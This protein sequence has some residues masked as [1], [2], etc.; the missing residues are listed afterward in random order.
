MTTNCPVH[1]QE[2]V[3]RFTKTAL[4]VGL[5]AAV[6]GCGGSNFDDRKGSPTTETQTPAAI[7][8]PIIDCGTHTHQQGEAMSDEV[9]ACLLNA[10]E[11]GHP[12][13]LKQT[14]PT[15]EGD[16]ITKTYKVLSTGHVEIVTDN[17]QD[18]LGS[19]GIVAMTCTGSKRSFMVFEFDYC[20]DRRTLQAQPRS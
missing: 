15:V 19:E 1:T 7:P 8:I 6:L 18:Q 20:W 14:F 9:V 12:A 4:L 10:V 2:E 5:I 13:R 16:P 3:M 17:T 11:T